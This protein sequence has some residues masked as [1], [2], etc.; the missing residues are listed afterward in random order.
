VNVFVKVLAVDRGDPAMT[1]SAVVQVNVKD[2]DDNVAVFTESSYQF[3][4]AENSPVGV[5]VGTVRATDDDLPPYNHVYYQLVEDQSDSFNIDPHNGQRL[6]QTFTNE[7]GLSAQ[8]L[9]TLLTLLTAQVKSSVAQ[10]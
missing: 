6:A 3:T 5:T 4:V 10:L 1:G 7:L 8:S 2:V 9:T